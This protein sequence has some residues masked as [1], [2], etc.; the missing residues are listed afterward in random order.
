MKCKFINENDQKILGAVNVKIYGKP[1]IF[2]IK[3][4]FLIIKNKKLK[5]VIVFYGEKLHGPMPVQTPM[6]KKTL[7]ELEPAKGTI[8]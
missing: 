7:S 4:S 3:R 5:H 1:E 2:I 6:N 8:W